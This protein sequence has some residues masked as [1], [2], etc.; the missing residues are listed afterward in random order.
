MAGPI[1]LSV[2]TP[3]GD[4]N[5]HLNLIVTALES[6]GVVLEGP[7]YQFALAFG[8]RV[9]SYEARCSSPAQ[10]KVVYE[11]HARFAIFKAQEVVLARVGQG[12]A[13][14]FAST[15][16]K[17]KTVLS[18]RPGRGR[19]CPS[20][21]TEEAWQAK[22]RI[23][24]ITLSSSLHAHIIHTHKHI[25]TYTDLVLPSVRSLPLPLSRPLL[26]QVCPRCGPRA[27]R[28]AQRPQRQGGGAQQQR[29]PRQQRIR[30]P[31]R[32]AAAATGTPS[33]APPAPSSRARPRRGRSARSRHP[34][35]SWGPC[36]PY[37]RSRSRAQ[38][39]DTRQLDSSSARAPPAPVKRNAAAALPL[40]GEGAG[41]T[42]WLGTRPPRRLRVPAAGPRVPGVSGRRRS[43]RP[44]L[45]GAGEEGR[46]GG[47]ARGAGRGPRRIKMAMS[48]IQ[49]CRSLAL[50]T[51]LLSFCFVHL[52]CLDFTVA[53]KEEWYT[54]F[55]NI[56]YAEPAPDPGPG[57]AGGGG[58]TELHTEKTECGRYGEHSPKQ[59]ARGEVVMA[60]SAHDRL[61]CDPNTKFAAP[62]HGK[63]WIA[64]I[65]KGNCTY[66][67]KIRNAFL[68]NASAVV[69]FN[70]GSNT[71][72]TI[73]MSHAGKRP[74]RVRGGRGGGG[75]PGDVGAEKDPAPAS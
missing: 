43:R 63:N 64:L 20:R 55:V 9:G 3:P 52:L 4:A 41:A 56:T 54:A 11:R 45:A 49:A 60:S 51:W 61:A 32:S 22:P 36:H 24:D 40:K 30:S 27:K 74:G 28:G 7:R 73:T 14:P 13:S 59:D 6:P 37:E 17:S 33:A 53:E 68:Q 71:N 12:V 75:A 23:F 21:K 62:A 57:V 66:R 47:R 15:W 25:R 42:P 38:E 48:L 67:D 8:P 29:P 34:A 5:T 1:S 58:G 10:D 65:P 46:R 19:C 26:R 72:E 2:N 39:P 44:G 16:T 31:D 50:S 18:L 69:I 70:V 35:R